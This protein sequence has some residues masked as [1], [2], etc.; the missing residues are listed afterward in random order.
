MTLTTRMGK[1]SCAAFMVMLLCLC[2]CGK[3]PSSP[4]SRPTIASERHL[5]N[6]TAPPATQP[7]AEDW[8]GPEQPASQP[9]GAQLPAPPTAEAGQQ[10]Y[11]VQQGEDLYSISCK[12]FGNGNKIADIARANPQIGGKALRTGQQ[13]I[14]PSTQPVRAATAAAPATRA[15]TRPKQGSVW[16]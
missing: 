9:A 16:D 2:G 7:A 5:V 4:A 8:Y 14:I 13:L 1:S 15:T 10:V 11:E 6:R 3:Q 12:F